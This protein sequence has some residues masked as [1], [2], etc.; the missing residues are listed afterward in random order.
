MTKFSIFFHF[1]QIIREISLSHLLW[2]FFILH[3][4]ISLLMF[5]ILK[6]FQLLISFLY[7]L[8]L[9][10]IFDMFSSYKKTN[11]TLINYAF[12]SGNPPLNG[13]KF[14]QKTKNIANI[15]RISN[16]IYQY[17]WCKHIHPQNARFNS[18]DS[19]CVKFL[20]ANY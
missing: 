5:L 12:Y 19:W 17:E 14:G 16:M 4:I 9:S 6:L 11:S 8:S 7:F 3:V 13:K 18:I 1:Y 10:E 15:N 2:L 20:C